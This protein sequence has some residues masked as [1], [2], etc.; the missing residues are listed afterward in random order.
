MKALLSISRRSARTPWSSR[1]APIPASPGENQPLTQRPVSVSRLMDSAF[2]RSGGGPTKRLAGLLST[3]PAIIAPTN[4]RSASSITALQ[5]VRR[6]LA[7]AA[8]VAARRERNGGAESAERVRLELQQRR[9]AVI[10][11]LVERRCLDCDR[12]PS[13]RRVEHLDAS[14]LPTFQD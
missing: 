1:T 2:S 8:I 6:M 4:G 11:R 7:V 9:P 3:S 10:E 5:S 14:V 13:V 12:L